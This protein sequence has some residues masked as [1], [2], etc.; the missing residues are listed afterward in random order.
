MKILI[1][2]VFKKVRLYR[3]VIAAVASLIRDDEADI[4]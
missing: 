2:R 3:I 1:K 4:A